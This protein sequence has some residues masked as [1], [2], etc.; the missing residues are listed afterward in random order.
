MKLL[1]AFFAILPLSTLYGSTDVME[2]DPDSSDDYLT[3]HLEADYSYPRGEK[4]KVS[5]GD[6][7]PEPS[8]KPKKQKPLS[9]DIPAPSTPLKSIENKVPLTPETPTTPKTRALYRSHGVNTDE[10]RTARGLTEAAWSPA[11]DMDRL[12]GSF[13]KIQEAFDRLLPGETPVRSRPYK[14]NEIIPEA[15][16]T[17]GF[18]R[19]SITAL[20]A[21]GQISDAL[22]PEDFDEPYIPETPEEKALRKAAFAE[23]FKAREVKRGL[24]QEDILSVY[25]KELAFWDDYLDW[26][27]STRAEAESTGQRFGRDDMILAF[28]ELVAPHYKIL[29]LGNGYKVFYSPETLDLD[30]ENDVG[31]TNLV[32]LLRGGCPIGHDGKPMNFHHFTLHDFA[33]HGSSYGV[34]YL[35]LI[36][37]KLHTEY[38]GALHPPKSVYKHVPRTRV[39]RPGFDPIRQDSCVGLGNLLKPAKVDG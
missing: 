2:I 27:T 8:P 37:E 35:I 21:S 24:S 38:S 3:I 25:E 11:P 28:D 9:S 34:T 33:T 17:A 1:L 15:A 31:E 30:R 12:R 5:G 22:K 4:R 7:S 16:I 10:R 13:R 20:Q 6:Y 29:D 23:R 14:P 36:S 18:P 39:L 19:R 26:M 32:I